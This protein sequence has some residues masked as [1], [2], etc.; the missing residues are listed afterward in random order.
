MA[1]DSQKEAFN[2]RLK[3][4]GGS[5]VAN[6]SSQQGSRGK[7]PGKSPSSGV[8]FLW[9]CV[10][11]VWGYF[12]MSAIIFANTHYDEAWI[13]RDA[14]PA[15]FDPIVNN[16]L[17]GLGSVVLMLLVA[18]ASFTFLRRRVGLRRFVYGIPL[19]FAAA[20]LAVQLTGAIG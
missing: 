17:F 12:A 20:S 15:A 6:A 5:P 16:V 19:G 13:L 4:I 18:L 10:G 3:R 14:D 7:L 9:L 2:E 8:A 1:L 11:A